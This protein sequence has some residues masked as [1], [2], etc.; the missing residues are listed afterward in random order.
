MSENAARILVVDD[1]PQIRRLLRVALTAHGFTVLEAATGEGAVTAAATER[2]DVVVLDLGLPDTDGLEVIRRLRQWTRVPILVLSV[3]DREPE[4]VAA[5]DAGADDY[6]TKPFGMGELL[7]RIRVALRRQIAEGEEPV[8]RLGGLTIDLAARRVTVDGREVRLTPTEYEILRVLA[9]H[10]GRVLTHRQILREVWGPAYQDET[11][12]LRVYV[13]Q[14]RRKI[15]PEPARPRY[16]ITETGVGYR[17]Q[18]PHNGIA[19]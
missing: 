11:H 7:A 10:P 19:S 3:R 2:P 18:D 6:V 15:E 5:L 17:L 1:E 9:R 12:Y 8:V 13:A 16:L 4:K 14:L